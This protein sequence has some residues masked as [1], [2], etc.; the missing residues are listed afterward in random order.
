[1]QRRKVN[2]YQKASGGCEAPDK[3]PEVGRYSRTKVT[4][5]CSSL[6]LVAEVLKLQRTQR[7]R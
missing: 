4:R 1:M 2:E 6:G 5:T 3:R 7:G